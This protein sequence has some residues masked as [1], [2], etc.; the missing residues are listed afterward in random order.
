[1]PNYSPQGILNAKNKLLTFLLSKLT[2]TELQM[3]KGEQLGLAHMLEDYD[4]GFYTRQLDGAEGPSAEELVEVA[5]KSSIF[6]LMMSK[7]DNLMLQMGGLISS[8]T[9]ARFMTNELRAKVP[10]L[11]TY[12]EVSQNGSTVA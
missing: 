8:L 3:V 12:A 10:E 9:H 2:E 6:M 7:D 11:F 4:V 1:M 5:H